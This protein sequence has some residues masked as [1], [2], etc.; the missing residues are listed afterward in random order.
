MLLT[1]KYGS[2]VLV[3]SAASFAQTGPPDC[4]A[5]RHSIVKV[6]TQNAI[7]QTATQNAVVVYLDK[8][9]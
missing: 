8:L 1:M 9:P 3:L 4:P 5:W 6:S 2:L 7:Q